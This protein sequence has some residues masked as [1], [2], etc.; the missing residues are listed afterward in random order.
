MRHTLEKKTRPY[1]LVKNLQAYST[2]LVN[3]IHYTGTCTI[4]PVLGAR[5]FFLVCA[6]ATCATVVLLC[7]TH[8]QH[9]SYNTLLSSFVKHTVS[10]LLTTHCCPPL[11][12]TLSASLQHT[13]VLLCL[14]HCQHPSYNTLLSSFV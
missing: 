9:P 3:N 14:A 8:C 5:H 10:I 7:L 4:L 1:I 11:F 13:V 6:T 12:S 2:Y